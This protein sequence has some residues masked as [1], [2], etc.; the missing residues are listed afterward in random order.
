M[1]RK[2]SADLKQINRNDPTRT[3]R[4]RKRIETHAYT[5]T[6]EASAR[7][8][9]ATQ[10]DTGVAGVGVRCQQIIKKIHIYPVV[11]NILK[12]EAQGRELENDKDTI[13]YRQDD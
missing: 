13:L 2:K 5:H 7:V 3:T 4:K 1:D 9:L 6:H 8:E 12:R 11:I 10:L